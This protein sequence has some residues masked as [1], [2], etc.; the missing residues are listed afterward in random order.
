MLRFFLVDVEQWAYLCL[1]A[2]IARCY[3]FLQRLNIPPAVRKLSTVEQDLAES[4]VVLAKKS[5]PTRSF[6]PVPDDFRLF[7]HSGLQL[8]SYNQ[9]YIARS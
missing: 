4:Y 5:K 7:Y 9:P 1:L 8:D 6:H 3:Q 2:R